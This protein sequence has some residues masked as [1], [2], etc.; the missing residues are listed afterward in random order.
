M[1]AIFKSVP[2]AIHVSFL[3]LSCP[4][5]QKNGLRLALIRI[6]ESIGTLN[7]RQAAFLDYLIGEKS[8]NVDFDGLTSDEVRAQCALVAGAV[9]H[10]LPDQERFVI[11]ARFGYGAERK[12]GVWG[13]TRLLRAQLNISNRKAILALIGAHLMADHCRKANGLSYKAIFDETGIPIRTLERAAQQIRIKVRILE[14]SAYDRLS[15]MFERDGLVG[16][17][18]SYSVQ[19]ETA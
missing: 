14:N 5:R 7:R 10:H 13:L 9:R 12:A 15:P 6:I 11:W 2:Q 4:P 18:A 19:G 17:S 16:Q 1:D 3:I 8:S